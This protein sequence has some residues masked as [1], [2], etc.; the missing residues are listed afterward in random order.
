MK[1]FSLII[2]ALLALQNYTS[3]QIAGKW[4]SY[5]TTLLTKVK[6]NRMHPD[7]IRI[8][9]CKNTRYK[10]DIYSTSIFPFLPKQPFKK[11][12]L[13]KWKLNGN[14]DSL[15][16][17]QNYEKWAYKLQRQDFVFRII[18]KDNRIIELIG[19][20][21]KMIYP[22]DPNQSIWFNRTGKIQLKLKKL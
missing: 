21:K 12:Y 3:A 8:T 16:L 22:G 1:N 17:F 4:M 7:S 6:D 14:G 9:F 19:F 2:I 20:G 18:R 5:D 10:I 11:Y 15:I 13:G